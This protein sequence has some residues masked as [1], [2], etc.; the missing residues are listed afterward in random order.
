[1]LESL[2]A[3]GLK[4]YLA[5]GT[6]EVDVIKEAKLLNIAHYFDGGIRGA[7]DD[8]NSFSKAALVRNMVENAGYRGEEILVF[9][10]GY[11]E[12]EVVK[13]VGGIAVGVCSEEPACL[14]VDQWKRKRLA[15]VGADFIVPNFTAHQP[16]LQAIFAE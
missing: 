6:D 7:S 16:L 1:M 11:V 13:N 14:Q 3:R 10:D 4:L 9:G 15:G 2:R 5:S 8:I 12:V